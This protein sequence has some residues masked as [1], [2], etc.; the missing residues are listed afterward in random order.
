MFNWISSLFAGFAFD[1][2]IYSAGLAS[3]NG[4]QQL[5]EPEGLQKLAVENKKAKNVMK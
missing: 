3:S 4:M 2:A 1:A 5:K